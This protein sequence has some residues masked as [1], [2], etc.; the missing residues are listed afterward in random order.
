MQGVDK[1][2]VPVAERH[3]TAAG[4]AFYIHAH[5]FFWMG[6]NVPLVLHHGI[7]GCGDS[8]A[9]HDLADV[10]GHVA[11]QVDRLSQLCRRG[12]ELP[13]A[14][15]AVAVKL[16]MGQ[17]QGPAVGSGNG[18]KRCQV[19]SRHPQ[20]AAVDMQGMRNADGFQCIE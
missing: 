17:V 8:L 4:V 11:V 18:L 5:P 10:Y 12:R 13:V 7:G 19:I 20:V 9:E 15:G 14:L 16:Y 3:H 1:I 2:F 6:V